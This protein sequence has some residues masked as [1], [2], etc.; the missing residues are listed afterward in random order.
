MDSHRIGIG[1]NLHLARWATY[2]TGRQRWFGRGRARFGVLAPGAQKERIQSSQKK[3]R[4]KGKFWT[5]KDSQG[6]RPAE[7]GNDFY[8]ICVPGASKP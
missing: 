7:A 4:G 1:L 3:G 8:G 5:G 6:Q 2:L